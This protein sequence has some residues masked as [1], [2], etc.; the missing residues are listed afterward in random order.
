MGDINRGSLDGNCGKN[1]EKNFENIFD[2]NSI[3]CNPC[4]REI[5]RAFWAGYKQGCHDAPF[6]RCFRKVL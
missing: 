5:K 3:F 4:E 6:C 1:F 2:S